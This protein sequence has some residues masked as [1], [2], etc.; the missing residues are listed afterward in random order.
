MPKSDLCGFHMILNATVSIIVN[1]PRYSTDRNTPTRAFGLNFSLVKARIEFSICL[2]AHKSLLSGEL[3]YIRNLLQPVPISSLRS[4]TSN[5]LVVPFLS[6][7]ITVDCS[8]CHCAPRFYALLI[9]CLLSRTN[10]KL[11]FFEKAHELENLVAKSDCK[12]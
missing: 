12:V 9:N 8:F 5:R 2:L 11:F 1:M 4:S 3:R 7:Q 6:R 10:S